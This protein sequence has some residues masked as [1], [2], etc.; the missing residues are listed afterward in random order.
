MISRFLEHVFVL[1]SISPVFLAVWL[2]E[3]VKTGNY[4]NGLFWLILF[5]FLIPISWGIIKFSEKKLEILPIKVKSVAPADREVSAFLI[6]YILP[7]LNIVNLNIWTILFIVGLLYIAVLTTSNYHFN[8]VLSLF[9][10]YHYYEV[11][12]EENNGEKTTYVLMTKKTIR[13]S[14]SINKIVQVSD[15]MLMEVN[16]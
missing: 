10:G 2:S 9:F 13:N 15:Y 6:A 5:V 8:P 14:R 16:I 1:T 12:I 7:M 4:E 3:F 11:E